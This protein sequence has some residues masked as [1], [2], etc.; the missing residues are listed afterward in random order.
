MP[1]TQGKSFFA[2]VDIFVE[3][4]KMFCEVLGRR[5]VSLQQ[6]IGGPQSGVTGADDGNVH[7]DVSGERFPRREVVVDGVEPEA[8]IGVVEV[9]PVSIRHPS[10]PL[11]PSRRRRAK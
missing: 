5:R 2:V 10:K 3:L 7:I 8:D 11:D 4:S 1:S 9:H 6:V